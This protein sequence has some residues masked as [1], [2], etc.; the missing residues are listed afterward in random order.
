MDASPKR[1]SER[2][3]SEPEEYGL[4]ICCRARGSPQVARDG[5]N[6]A[7]Y[8][9]LGRSP[10]PP[11]PSDTGAGR[12]LPLPITMRGAPT[13]RTAQCCDNW[14]RRLSESTGRRKIYIQRA[15]TC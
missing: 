10:T 6:G 4:A 15:K 3:T 2:S 7:A 12:I 5:K 1:E 9:R 11:A 8:G 13:I 14:Q